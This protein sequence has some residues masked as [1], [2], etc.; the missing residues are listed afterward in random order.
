M[1][2]TIANQKGGVGKTT[3]SLSLAEGLAREG[4]KV[5]IIDLDAQANTTKT[6]RGKQ[7]RGSTYE[8]LTG[9]ATLEGILQETSVQNLFLAPASYRLATSD[10]DVKGAGRESRLKGSISKSRSSSTT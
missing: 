7:N 2:Y 4:R 9:T 6:L 3:T 8:L 5:L 10:I 1:I